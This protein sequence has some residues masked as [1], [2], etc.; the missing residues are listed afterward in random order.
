MSQLRKSASFRSRIPVKARLPQRRCSSPQ[1]ISSRSKQNRKNSRIFLE[2]YYSSSS[3]SSS[4]ESHDS[5]EPVQ[6]KDFVSY[7]NN[8]RLFSL[9]MLSL[10]RGKRSITIWNMFQSGDKKCEIRSEQ[11]LISVVNAMFACRVE[12]Q[13]KQKIWENFSWHF[14]LTFHFFSSHC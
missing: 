9:K 6:V 11:K 10:T 8:F 3:F 1:P 14:F 2:R 7:F 5:E 12:Q 13:T 4:D